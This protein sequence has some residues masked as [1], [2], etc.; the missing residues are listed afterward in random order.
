MDLRASAFLAGL[1]TIQYVSSCRHARETGTP[2]IRSDS[3]HRQ[4]CASALYDLAEDSI[5][6]GGDHRDLRAPDGAF[7]EEETQGFGVFG[8]VRWSGTV[9]AG[10]RIATAIVSLCTSRPR[11]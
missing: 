3:S 8:I 11:A 4:R 6:V 5:R 1:R 2:V 10:R 7:H 9:S